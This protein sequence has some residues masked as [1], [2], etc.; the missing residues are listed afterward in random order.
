MAG[1]LAS[2]KFIGSIRKWCVRA[3]WRWHAAKIRFEVPRS[4]VACRYSIL[5]AIADAWNIR[6]VDQFVYLTIRT[7]EETD[8]NPVP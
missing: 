4:P 3:R 1:R 7:E 5:L 2:P 6:L 8:D